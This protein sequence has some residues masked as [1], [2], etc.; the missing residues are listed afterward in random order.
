MSIKPNQ[1]LYTAARLDR[2]GGAGS[3]PLGVDVG[4]EQR[5]KFGLGYRVHSSMLRLRWKAAI[6]TLPDRDQR[7]KAK[8][9]R[10]ERQ[11]G[12]PPGKIIFGCDHPI[13]AWSLPHAALCYNRY[14]VVNG[15]TAYEACTD[16]QYSGK[17]ATYAEMVYGFL[18][19]AAKAGPQWRQGV[20]LGKTMQG[21]AHVSAV[22]SGDGC[23]IFTTR[24]VRRMPRPWSLDFVS[25]VESMPWDFGYAALGS[26]L[27]LAKRILP[28]QAVPVELPIDFPFALQQQAPATP[29]EAAEDP[30]DRLLQMVL[31]L[32]QAYPRVMGMTC[33]R[34]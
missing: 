15:L 21:D 30:P 29:D 4:M 6:R 2:R 28:P 13:Y 12:A 1:R 3:E 34:G 33:R 17:I 10:L 7:A 9:A 31:Q 26:K 24:S 5:A 16:R 22:P 23:G 19:T 27:I 11:G 8:A 18:K 25:N 14:R 20:W 32:R